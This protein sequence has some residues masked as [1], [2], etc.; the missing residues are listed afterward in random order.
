MVFVLLQGLRISAASV[1]IKFRA[2][3]GHV[4]FRFRL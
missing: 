4:V 1:Q 2:G 3:V